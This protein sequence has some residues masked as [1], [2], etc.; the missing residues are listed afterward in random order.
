MTPSLPSQYKISASNTQNKIYL[1]SSLIC[2]RVDTAAWTHLNSALLK[3]HSHFQIWSRKTFDMVILAV[4]CYLSGFEI[5]Q[6][7]TSH[8]TD[9]RREEVRIASLNAVKF[10]IMKIWL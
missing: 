2:P 1:R 8:H 10:F 9:N 3:L 4:W 7:E 5:I 6:W